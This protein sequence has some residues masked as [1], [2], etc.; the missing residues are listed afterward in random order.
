MQSK[1]THLPVLL[2]GDAFPDVGQAWGHQSPANGLLAA[3]GQLDTT[4]LCQAYSHGIFPWYNIGQPVLW[5]SPDPRMTLEIAKF[6][7]HRSMRKTLQKFQNSEACEIRFDTAFNQVITACAN[8]TR[9]GY[10]LGSSST[11]I[12]PEMVHAYCDLHKSGYAHSVETWVNG[13]LVGGLYCVALGKAIFGESMFS[14]T[15][16]A[17]KIALSALVGFCRFHGIQSI[18]CQQNTKHLASMGGT[19][20]SR[21]D[22]LSH[23]HCAVQQVAPIWKFDPIYWER[24]L[25]PMA[26]DQ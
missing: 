13:Q 3:G 5:W 20:I 9:N 10:T 16:N 24:I 4:T 18:D 7:L 19:E 2:P 26:L 6:K 14:V 25:K 23:V 15:S 17:S 11:W 12:V 21:A 1:R 22:F 8:S